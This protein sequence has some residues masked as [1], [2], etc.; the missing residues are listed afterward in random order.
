MA[1][2]KTGYIDK[3]AGSLGLQVILFGSIF[4]VLIFPLKNSPMVNITIIL[5][6]KYSWFE[7]ASICGCITL[8]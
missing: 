7:E 8:V 5:R 1:K 2:T 6:G 4:C 3:M